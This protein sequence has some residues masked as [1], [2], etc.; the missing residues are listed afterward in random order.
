MD[1]ESLSVSEE[2]RTYESSKFELR[3][4]Q[5][6]DASV[7]IK[8]PKVSLVRLTQ[9]KIKAPKSVRDA[10]H[11]NACG[12]D[13]KPDLTPLTFSKGKQPKVELF[14][15]IIHGGNDGVHVNCGHLTETYMK[16]TRVQFAA[17]RGM[18]LSSDCTVENCTITKNGGE[19]VKTRAS[20]TQKGTKNKI[21]KGP[22]DGHD[23]SD[24]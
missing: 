2:S 11:L 7:E 24:P 19:G 17:D 13:I 10:L 14:S 5:F 6:T 18:F 23:Q 21:Q 8:A 9:V 20:L 22:A 12:K 1:E 3:G 4:L 16:D 15:C